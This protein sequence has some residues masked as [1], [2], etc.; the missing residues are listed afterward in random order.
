MLERLSIRR[1]IRR[2]WSLTN[3]FFWRTLGVLWL[4]AVIVSVIAQIVTTPL[5][6]LFSVV[7]SLVDPNA[8]FGAYLPAA[9]LYILTLLV[10]LVFG[11]VAAVVQSAAVALVYIDLRMRKEGLDLDLQRFVEAAPGSDPADPYL[12]RGATGVTGL[13]GHV[14]PGSP[15]A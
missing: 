14:D 5:S 13:A 4:I 11:A 10:G 6:L 8:S 15:G 12:S 1:S 3:G 7:I 9:G 2:S